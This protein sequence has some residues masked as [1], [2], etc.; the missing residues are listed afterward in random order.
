MSYPIHFRKK[1]LAKLEEGQSIRAVAQHFEINKNTIVEWKKRIEIKRTRPRKPSKVDDD[2][3]RADVEQYPDDYQYE[4]A[5]RF[6][7]ATSTIGDALKRLN[8]TVKKR[9]YGTR[10]QKG[11][12]YFDEKWQKQHTDRVLDVDG[13]IAIDCVHGRYVALVEAE[14]DVN[15]WDTY[16][17]AENNHWGFVILA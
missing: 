4:R 16:S 6:G 14:F 2:A 15:T 7:C 5:A 17:R 9:P 3:L 12:Q 10:K 1:I 11:K 13:C 8:I